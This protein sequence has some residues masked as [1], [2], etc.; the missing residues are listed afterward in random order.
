VFAPGRL[1][2]PQAAEQPA[3]KPAATAPAARPDLAANVYLVG[4]WSHGL[5]RQ[6]WLYDRGQKRQIVLRE[7]AA[8][9]VANVRGTVDAVR[10]DFIVLQIDGAARRLELGRNLGQLE[11]TRP[12]GP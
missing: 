7:G 4:S 9:E 10:P 12:N 6:A 2:Q 11:G 1:P 8:F 3:A 5:A